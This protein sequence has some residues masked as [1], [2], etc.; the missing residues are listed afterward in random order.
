MEENN[1]LIVNDNA[2]KIQL[3]RALSQRVDFL[4]SINPVTW[5]DS[6]KTGSLEDCRA[7]VSRLLQKA[8]KIKFEKE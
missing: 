8:K 2:E 7:A 1:R 4:D 5:D 3:I 6:D